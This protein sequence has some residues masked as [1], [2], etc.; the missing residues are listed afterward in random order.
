[1]TYLCDSVKACL[2]GHA[3]NV[4][5]THTMLHHAPSQKQIQSTP[6]YLGA[7]SLDTC[8]VFAHSLVLP[9]TVILE[10]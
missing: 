5:A 7:T 8:T 6:H 1:M 2:G 9:Q 3:S 10:I 4:A